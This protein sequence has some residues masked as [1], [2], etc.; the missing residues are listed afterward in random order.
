M[1]EQGKGV[2]LE[3]TVR[4]SRFDPSAH[5]KQFLGAALECSDGKVWVLDYNEQ[6]PFHAFAGCRVVVSGEPYTPEGQQLIGW[7]AGKK[8]G[9]FRVLTMRLLEAAR[10]AEFVE[11]GAA[12]HLRGRFEPVPTATADSTLSFV[13]EDGTAFLVA[14]D[15]AGATVGTSVAVC[16]YSLQRSPSTPKPPERY[17]WIIGPCSAADVWEWRRRHS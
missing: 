8:L 1:S 16:A 2:R 11:I 13:T 12:Q 9:H 14:N 5:G 3:G 17:L 15:P 4:A 10:D 7:R 6:S